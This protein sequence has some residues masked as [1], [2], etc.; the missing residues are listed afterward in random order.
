M[1]RKEYMDG[2]S[3]AADTFAWHNDYYKQFVTPELIVHVCRRIGMERILRALNSGDKHMN[4]IPLG[5]WDAMHQW[6]PPITRAKRKELGE[7][8]SLGATVCIAK[9][10]ARMGADLEALKQIVANYHRGDDA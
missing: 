8:N 4:T 10:A 1:N 7:G 3:K 2:S 9:C 6:M 5:E